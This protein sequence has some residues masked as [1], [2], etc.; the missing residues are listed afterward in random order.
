MEKLSAPDPISADVRCQAVMRVLWVTLRKARAGMQ[1]IRWLRG[2]PTPMPGLT[3]AGR[4][5]RGGEVL[6]AALHLCSV[7]NRWGPCLRPEAISP[8]SG[9]QSWSLPKKA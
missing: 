1:G 5:S 3:H 2:S 6:K 8:E 4:K 9:I 7:D